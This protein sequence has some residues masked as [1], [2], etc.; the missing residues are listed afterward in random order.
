[1]GDYKRLMKNI[2]IYAMFLLA[3]FIPQGKHYHGVRALHCIISYHNMNMGPYNGNYDREITWDIGTLHYFHF[4]Q[5]LVLEDFHGRD[6]NEVD[7][8]TSLLYLMTQV[9]QIFT[10]L[11]R[12][13]FPRP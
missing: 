2:T 13:D 12:F 5:R 1:M 8:L 4:H 6:A 11:T 9:I 10:P 7:F 3:L